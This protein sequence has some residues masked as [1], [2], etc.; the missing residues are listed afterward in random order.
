MYVP[1]TFTIGNFELAFMCLNSIDRLIFKMDKHYV[2]FEE[3]K[4][5]SDIV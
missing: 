4:T 1:L 3:G 5:I 2:L